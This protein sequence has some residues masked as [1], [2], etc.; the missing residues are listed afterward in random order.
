MYVAPTTSGSAGDPRIAAGAFVLGL[1]VMYLPTIWGAAHT[2][3]NSEDYAHGPLIVAVSAWWFWHRRHPLREAMGAGAGV[4]AWMLLLIGA[5]MYAVGRAQDVWMLQIGSSIPVLSGGIAALFGWHAVRTVRFAILFLFFAIPLPGSIV[6]ELTAPLKRGVSLTAEELLYLTGYPVAR[7]G[8]VLSLGQY[9]LLIADACSGLYSMT[10]LL[11]LAVVYVN[12]VRHAGRLRNA[13][14]LLVSLPIAFAANVMRVILL[15][16]ITY[17]WGDAAGHGFL[18]GAAGVLMFSF[19]LVLIL[20][21]DELL[22]RIWPGDEFGTGAA[23]S[24]I[25][26]V[27]P[28]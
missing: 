12:A 13:L 4:G 17:Y 8:V 3:W 14:I 9:K 16:L 27:G 19:A 18:H 24:G 20:V 21:C 7:D 28:R 11:A 26:T 1:A 23:A 15:G 10:S 25:E 5:A 2:L 22:A 6:D